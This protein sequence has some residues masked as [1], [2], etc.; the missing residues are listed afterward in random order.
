M[1]GALMVALKK[2]IQKPNPLEI[3]EVE[4]FQ[5]RMQD[6]IKQ[7][8]V[9][10]AAEKAMTGAGQ[11]EADV[12]GDEVQKIMKGRGSAASAYAKGS[13]EHFT[14]TAAE[15]LQI[16]TS[17]YPEPQTEAAFV[18]L[19]QESPLGPSKVN[20][21]PGKTAIL[22]HV[23]L[24]LIGESLRRPSCKVPPLD[25]CPHQQLITGALK[26]RGASAIGRNNNQ[27]DC[28]VEGDIILV[29]DSR[30][31]STQGLAP[32]RSAKCRG[33][34]NGY[35]EHF[36]LS[37][38][39]NQDSLKAKKKRNRGAMNQLIKWHFLT[40]EPLD[41]MVP[42]KKHEKYAGTCRG[43]A[44]AF[45]SLSPASQVWHTTVEEKKVPCFNSFCIFFESF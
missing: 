7:K 1:N 43:N 18:K 45:V 25:T 19:V 12:S 33:Q 28:P 44:L 37:L 30:K 38:I 39:L 31:D 9:E 42:E 14:A 32:F 15:L 2:N 41:K 29:C 24:Q 36:E 35:L 22:I 23:D 20:G 5:L 34:I 21:G 27:V 16:Y 3:V 13:E 4:T 26:G 10:Q 17:F 8:D 40:R 11:D 6:C